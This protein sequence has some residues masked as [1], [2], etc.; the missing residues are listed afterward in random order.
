MVLI[1]S[2]CLKRYPI[3]FLFLYV[4]KQTVCLIIWSVVAF[5][6]L[7]VSCTYNPLS[8]REVEV[9]I[10]SRHQW[11]EMQNQSFWYTL[12]WTEAGALKQRHLKA[13]EK[14]VSLWVKRGETVV[15]CAYPLGVFSPLGG[16]LIPTAGAEV[17]LSPQEGVLCHH[18][19]E[20]TKINELSLGT[21]HY[22]HLL[23]EIRSKVEDFTLLDGTRLQKDLA[24]GE[25][26]S[27]SIQVQEPLVV[28][29][30]TIPQGYWVAE[31]SSDRSFW[32]YWGSEGV[33]LSLGEGLHCF[34]NKEDAL[35]LRIFVDLSGHTSFVS[36]QKGPL[37]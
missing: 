10:P 18:L 6:S 31:R 1:L 9:V 13:G 25:L 11:E 14:R 24:N 19:L 26:R 22:S 34:W 27:S 12:V 32:L 28:V 21:L 5:S 8:M 16:A 2:P 29:V 3:S 17:R 35:L 30:S 36:V 15:F 4:N 20:S 37:W 33:S 7:T 23:R